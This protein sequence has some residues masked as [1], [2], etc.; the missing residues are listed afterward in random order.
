MRR[1]TDRPTE[2]MFS[3]PESAGDRQR[4]STAQEKAE[5]RDAAVEM[6]P[7]GGDGKPPPPPAPGATKRLL[8]LAMEEKPDLFH[9]ADGRAWATLPNGRTFDLR[10]REARD[11]LGALYFTRD[12]SAAKSEALS[13]VISTLEARARFEG[14]TCE[15]FVRVAGVDGAVYLDLGDHGREVV[16]IA[17]GG[18]TIAPAPATVRFHRPAGMLALPRPI[19]GGSLAPLWPLI[20][21]DSGTGAERSRA[22]I[23]AYLVGTFH[24]NGPYPVL[25]LSGEQGSGKSAAA[26]KLRGLIDPSTAD[27]RSPPRS[28]HDLAIAACNGWIVTMDNLSRLPQWLSD[29]LCRVATGGA[30]TTRTLYS[31][32]DETL[33]SFKRPVLAT[34]IDLAMRPDLLSRVL[35][36]DLPAIPEERRRT[37]E[38][39]APDFERVRPSVL[40]AL[41]DAVALAL[42]NRGRV[43]RPRLPRMADLA[44]WATAAEPALGLPEGAVERALADNSAEVATAGLES[45]P[46]YEPL[47]SGITTRWEGT[48]EELR[49][50]LADVLGDGAKPD[51]WPRSP[52]GLVA[53]IKRLAPNLRAVGWTVTPPPPTVSHGARLWRLAPPSTGETAQIAQTAHSTRSV[54]NL[55]HLHGMALDHRNTTDRP[56]PPMTARGTPRD[57][58]QVGDPGGLGGPSTP[59]QRERAGHIPTSKE[60]TP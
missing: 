44:V 51:G 5:A 54:P 36:V 15:V 1:I 17:A 59:S 46:I 39:I 49:R 22:L 53:E 57:S 24:P 18:W 34:A 23:A 25:L 41:L 29:A 47:C 43:R 48:A 42:A 21:L 33:L 6:P 40:G 26:R 7:K 37:E 10:S 8:A 9:S 56:P 52:R 4:L 55:G 16:C 60:T 35:L 28:E 45:S 11:W 58:A 38:E 32:R 19:R 50:L 3:S 13:E 2:P 31:D 30:F 14:A 27:I 12:G 20:N